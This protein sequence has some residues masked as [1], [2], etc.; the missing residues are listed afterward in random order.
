M[1]TRFIIWLSTNSVTTWLIRNLA[2]R[3]DPLIFKATNGRY[4]S[5]GAP[6]MP[7]LTMTAVGRNSGR[8]RAVHLACIEHEGDFLVVASAMGQQRHPAWRYNIE[9]NPEV[10]IQLRGERFKARARVLSNAEKE[11]VWADIREAIPQMDVYV[12]RTDRNIRVFRLSRI[13]P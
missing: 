10:E 5:M 1:K 3:M 13:N 9:A 7:M 11:R 2:S 4:T 8:P 12:R 6:S